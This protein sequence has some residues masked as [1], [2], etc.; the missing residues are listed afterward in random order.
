MLP[1]YYIFT[2]STRRSLKFYTIDMRSLNIAVLLLVTVSSCGQ[3]VST[4][5]QQSSDKSTSREAVAVYQT[6]TGE[7]CNCTMNTIRGDKPSTTFDSCYKAIVDKYTDTLKTMGCDPASTVGQNKLSNGIQLYRCSDLY[8]LIEKEFS[9]EE[10][11][12]LLFKGEFVSQK[13][14]TTGEYEIILKDGK[15]KEQKAFK[16]KNPFDEK[17]VEAYLPGYEVTIEYEIVTNLETN[18]DEFYIKEGAD[19]RGV[20]AV[21]VSKQK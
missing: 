21:P 3:S 12:K 18:K 16:A 5:K 11:K 8:H 15:T 6:M 14:L 19:I 13:K 7:I 20:G 17:S 9:E 4:D 1:L 2:T 10:A